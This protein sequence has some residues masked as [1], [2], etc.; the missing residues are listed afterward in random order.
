MNDMTT[1]N[2]VSMEDMMR[3]MITES[4][5]KTSQEEEHQPSGL[6]GWI[7]PVCGSGVSPY[8]N[9]CP[10][11]VKYRQQTI[12]CSTGTTGNAPEVYPGYTTSCST[13]VETDK[14]KKPL[15]S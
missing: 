13:D 10:N 7:C 15:F 5:K 9:V 14:P 3:D 12:W 1:S 4:D 6:Y 8:Q 11:C 2:S